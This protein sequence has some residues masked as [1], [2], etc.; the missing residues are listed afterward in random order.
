LNFFFPDGR[1]PVMP[2]SLRSWL[3]VGSGLIAAAVGLSAC[4]S[5]KSSSSSSS[6]KP[7]TLALTITGAGKA[8][9]YSGPASVKGGL[10]QLQLKNTGKQPHGAQLVLVQGS[11]TP[12][13][14]L[15]V[16]SA[17]SDK[18]PN[19]IRGAG[20]IGSV[21]P[22]GT[23]TATVNLA[24]GKYFVADVGGPTQGPPAYRPFTVTA[25]KAGTLPSTSTALT[26]AA[27]GKDKYKWEL[28]GAF[29]AGA[30]RFTFN[31]KG[32]DALHFVGAFRVTGNPSKAQL[33]KAL[34]SNGKPPPFV[35]PSSFQNT[36][37]LDGGKSEVTSLQLGKPG[38]WV[39]WCPLT[40]R[41][42]GKPHFEEGLL[43]TVAVK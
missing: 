34:K 24:P 30:N 18:T 25:G 28:S 26:A 3:F 43:T 42:G 17:N 11:H 38:N 13:Q 7:T 2:A 21:P 10:V 27:N 14:A 40:D 19:W 41:D 31:S 1:T 35:D 29:K 39:L 4:G 22:G 36:A 32:K 6:P 5:S 23:Q 16:I 9:K 37:V 15:Q 8:A 20:G 33:I 12:Q